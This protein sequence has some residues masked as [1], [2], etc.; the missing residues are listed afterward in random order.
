M[1]AYE[2]HSIALTVADF[3]ADQGKTGCVITESLYAGALLDMST[4]ETIYARLLS[5]GVTIIPLT[6]LKEIRGKT[7]VLRNTLSG[8]ETE[9][10]DIDTIVFAVD[11]LPNDD[12]YRA[13]KGKI[14][15]LHMIGQCV[16]PRRLLDSIFDGAR[17]GNTI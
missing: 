8:A 17:A 7:A 3:L 15:D 13:L 16:S 14:E 5:K 6:G 9:M 11:G 12:L 1:V 4:L 2:D 10:V